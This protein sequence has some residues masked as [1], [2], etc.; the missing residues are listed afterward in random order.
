MTHRGG[1]CLEGVCQF[2]KWH[3]GLG[4]G[5]ETR[6]FY[7]SKGKGIS[8]HHSNS[9]NIMNFK[10]LALSGLLATT[11]LF[12]G[13]APAEARVVTGSVGGFRG[14]TAVD[15]YNVDTLYIPFTKGTGVV[16]VNC[17]TGDYNWNGYM[18]KGGALAVAR[19]WC[20]Y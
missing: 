11:A 6:L 2:N 19:D 14:V 7:K 3:K 20:G 16:N 5:L 4:K 15:R 18:T 12:G 8:P 17:A 9:N 10:S 13:M 1:V